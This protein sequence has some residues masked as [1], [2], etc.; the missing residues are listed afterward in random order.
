MVAQI[1]VVPWRSDLCCPS[2]LKDRLWN[3]QT[4]LHL[5]VHPCVGLLPGECHVVYEDGGS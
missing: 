4:A 3:C 2:H 1:A 5:A